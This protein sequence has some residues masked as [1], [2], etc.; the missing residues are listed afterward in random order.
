MNVAKLLR[1]PV[2]KK[3][4]ERLFEHFALRAN[5]IASNM[6]NEEDIF[7]KTKQKN[8]SKSQLDEKNLPFHDARDHFAFPD[9]SN[10]YLRRRLPNIIKDDSSERL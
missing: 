8:H 10:T 4:C 3:I 6:G 7:S 1:T 2:L 9:F 5:N